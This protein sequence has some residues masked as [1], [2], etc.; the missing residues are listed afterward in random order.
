MNHLPGPLAI[1][2]GFIGFALIILLITNLFAKKYL[3]GDFFA[4]TSEE[5]DNVA[6]IDFD[7]GHGGGHDPVHYTNAKEKTIEMD[8][9]VEIVRDEIETN[10]TI[11]RKEEVEI[12]QSSGGLVWKNNQNPEISPY[13]LF[14][15]QSALVRIKSEGFS[16]SFA[17]N[18][19]IKLAFQHDKDTNI[20]LGSIISIDGLN[21]DDDKKLSPDVICFHIKTI[22]AIRKCKAR[23]MWKKASMR[24]LSLTFSL[25]P[26]KQQYDQTSRICVRL[27]GKK[28]TFSSKP[29][30]YGECFIPLHSVLTAKSV[31]EMHREIFPKANLTPHQTSSSIE[32]VPAD[33]TD[34]DI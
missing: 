24:S 15:K 33:Y 19:K 32:S 5:E 25:G 4:V 34:D 14:S 13:E 18:S 10:V 26:L 17:S 28:K 20:V 11:E 31:L 29:K 9:V 21:F 7:Q 2:F 16:V 8:S 23:T 22:P 30:C 1:F 6:I 27:Y 3:N 12:A